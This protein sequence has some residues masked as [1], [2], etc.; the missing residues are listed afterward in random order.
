MVPAAHPHPEF[1]KYSPPGLEYRENKTYKLKKSIWIHDSCHYGAFS[2]TWPASMLIYYN[3]KIIYMRKEFN[4]QRIFG[5]HQHGRRFIVLETNM[6]AVK[7][8]ENALFL[9]KG[10]DKEG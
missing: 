8:C 9:D 7:S 2:L 3:Q 5:V 1:L 10:F 4:S 6:A